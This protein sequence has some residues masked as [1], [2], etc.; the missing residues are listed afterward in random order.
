MVTLADV[1]ARAGVSKSTASRSLRG[2]ASISRPTRERVE[3]AA[4]DLDF[5]V[6]PSARRLATGRTGTIGVVV[7]YITTWYFSQ[8]VSGAEHTLRVAGYD[9]IL[10]ILPDA[11]T[12]QRF[13]ATMPLRRRVDAVLL[14]TLPV[15]SSE[16]AAL[17]M[18]QVPIVTIGEMVPGVS[19]IGIDDHN[20]GRRA[21]EHLL[22]LGHRR[23]GLICGLQQGDFSFTAP[24]RRRQGFTVA[25]ARAGVEIRTDR[26]VTAE[27]TADGGVAAA[28]ALLRLAEPPTAVFAM[29]DEIAIGALHRLRGAGLRVPQDVSV[30]GV[31]DHPLA[32]TLGLT[33]IR[34][35]AA[36]QGGA[37]AELM[38]AQLR[39]GSSAFAPAQY[40]IDVELIDRGSTGPPP[41]TT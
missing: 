4:R 26:I 5:V 9:V 20:V 32:A 19:G 35:R 14:L 21:A 23:I 2:F 17:G 12:R 6:T 34:Q 1:A 24:H 18:L 41:D 40:R 33:T 36:A 15:T 39:P 37:A 30:I 13:F 16:V 22:E 31:D 10:V 3:R 7:P 11:G 29:S 28:S 25:C 38:L 27:F 8:V